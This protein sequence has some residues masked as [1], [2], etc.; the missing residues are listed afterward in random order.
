VIP[1]P[2]ARRPETIIDSAAAAHLELAQDEVDSITRAVTK[3]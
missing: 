1:I 3:D 2:G